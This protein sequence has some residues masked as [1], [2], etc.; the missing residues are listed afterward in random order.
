MKKIDVFTIII[1]YN[2]VVPVI[3]AVQSVLASHKDLK[4]ILID[5]SDD[6]DVFEN[7]KETFQ[8]SSKIILLKN[9]KNI[10]FS[11]AVNQG[12][13][14]AIDNMADYILLLNDDAYLDKECINHLI[15]ALEND[16]NAMLAGPTIFYHKFMNRVWHTGGFFNKILGNIKI[17]FKNKV[18]NYEYL[19]KFNPQEVDFLTGCVLMIKKEAVEKVGFFDEDL[20]FYGEDL[21]YS[22][23][24]KKKG[25]KLL[26]VP[27][28]FAWHDIDIEKGRTNP[29]VMYNLAKSNI[30]VRKKNFNKYYYFYYLFLHFFIYTPFRFY[31][32]LKGSRDFRAFL[33]WLK[34]SYDG[35]IYSG[36]SKKTIF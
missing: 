33:S 7:L 4:I 22:I 28:A 31:Q 36:I 21:D 3:E 20:F 13:K 30:I 11:K 9:K 17:P 6:P 8:N 32:I 19:K 5:N 26:W 2:K 34:G 14:I 1:S 23:R 35:L 25:Y 24:V 27:Y 18:I 10:G 15:N 29:F 16:K 12:I